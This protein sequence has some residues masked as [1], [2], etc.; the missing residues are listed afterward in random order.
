MLRECTVI[1]SAAGYH[2]DATAV[3]VVLQAALLHR[4][5]P[6]RSLFGIARLRNLWRSLGQSAFRSKRN[7]SI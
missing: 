4:V 5:T 1:W 3:R 7:V 6:N 2:T